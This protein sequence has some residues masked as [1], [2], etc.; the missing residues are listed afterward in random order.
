MKW[1]KTLVLF[2][3]LLA[4]AAYVY[5]Y[6]IK[7]GEKR[8]KEKEVSEQVFQFEPDSV[9][10]L[11]VRSVLDQFLFRREGDQWQILKPLVTEGETSTIN[12]ALTTLKNLK[13]E[14]EFT[15]KKN[16]LNS[17]GLVGTSTL[18][19]F[20][21]TSGVRD[22]V[23]FGD[24]TPVGSNA[25]AN[26]VDTVVFMVP[27]YAKKNFIKTLFDWRDKS[28][29]RVKQNEVKEFQ[30]RNPQGTFQLVK[31]GNDWQLKSPIKTRA[32]NS[33]VSST[34]SKLEYGKANTVAS[35]NFDQP[36]RYRLSKPAYEIDLVIG[37]SRAQKRIIFS[38]LQNN[39]AYARDMSRAPVFTVDSLFI[40]EINKSLFQLRYKKIAEFDRDN[41]D[42]VV[43][44]Q[45]DSLYVFTK[46]TNSTWFLNGNQ[47]VK[48]WKINSLLNT[49][50][51]LSAKKFLQENVSAPSQYGLSRPESKIFI[52]RHGEQI[53]HLDLAAPAGKLRV[54]FSPDSKI[55][56]EIEEST[57]NN[58]KVNRSE[59]VE[60][61]PP[62]VKQPEEN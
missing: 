39:L 4:L 20:E 43:V 55:V 17:Y 3:F 41:A 44:H 45:G 9:K 13:K 2:L 58:L 23:R 47:K 38:D 48:N 36:S 6:E 35:E 7:G 16:E 26:K 27:A 34:L 14:R 15:I 42:S 10:S 62:V 30:L 18:V 8:E 54:A 61:A 50:D 51:N 32:D 52:Y 46:D 37:D 28:I 19:I 21:L 33:S 22:S 53:Q 24:D 59:F 60:P 29:S 12:G 57:Y 40:K 11:E 49:L 25:F 31:E 1:M 56:A 5:F